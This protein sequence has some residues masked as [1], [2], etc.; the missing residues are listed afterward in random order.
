M[1]AAYPAPVAGLKDNVNLRLAFTRFKD[2][3]TDVTSTAAENPV[4]AGYFSTFKVQIGA[5]HPSEARTLVPST[6][7]MPY[8]NTAI[9]P[10]DEITGSASLPRMS[11]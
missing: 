3:K 4:P 6:A 10:P 2:K 5:S 1:D 8:N 11:S 9:P 7:S